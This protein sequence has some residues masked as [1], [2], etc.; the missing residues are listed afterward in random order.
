MKML[1]CS[2]V[3]LGAI[4]AESLD[5]E[6][7]HKWQTTHTEKFAELIDKA[8]QNNAAYV[9][10]FGSLFGRKRIPESVIDRLFVAAKEDAAIQILAFLQMEDFKRL[11]YR[12]DAPENLHLFCVQAEDSY[13]DEHIAFRIEQGTV[14]L[15]LG[16][17]ETLMIRTVGEGSFELS[18]LPKKHVIPSFEPIGFEDAQGR[19]CGYGVLEWS[20]ETLGE[21]AETKDQKFAFQ[22]RELKILPEDDET[23]ILKKIRSTVR[24]LGADTFLRV[25]LAGRSAFG[26]TINGDALKKQL[27]NKVFF[28]Q[29]FDNTVMDID[30]EAFE[31]DIYLRSEFV[32]LALKDD[33][34]SESERNQLIS[35]GWNAL[36]GREEAAE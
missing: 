33:S 23:A 1:F 24:R 11:S 3:R 30:E 15:Q 26:L 8:A 6:Q 19:V 27:Q 35:C 22:S 20:E 14:K 13:V 9:A 28:A 36:N 2:D 10:L 5:K 16:E 4:C 21:Y 34:L 29:V 7:A 17:H 12:N 18:G 31:T 25:T 32:R